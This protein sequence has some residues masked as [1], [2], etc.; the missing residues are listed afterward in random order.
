MSSSADASGGA[1]EVPSGPASRVDRGSVPHEVQSMTMTGRLVHRAIRIILEA[2]CR[3]YFRF[4][5]VGR[6]RLPVAGPFIIAPI[7]RSNIDFLIVGAAIPPHM[8]LRAMAKDS[9]WK[10]AWFGTFLEKMGSFPVNREHPG[11]GALRNCEEAL[12]HG[13][14]VLMFPEGRRMQGDQLEHMLDGPAWV[15][16]RYRVPVVPVGLGNTDAAMPIGAKFLHPVK[17]TAVIGEP[18]Y[19]DVPA[20]GRV[21][22]GAVAE[23]TERLRGEIQAVYDEARGA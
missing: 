22:R 17:V 3:L 8:I 12:A 4:R 6:D 9:L 16:C 21:P 2:F 7:H 5:V 11:R 14:P 20:T 23:F 18:I 10:V 13:D 1:G 19:P 15:A